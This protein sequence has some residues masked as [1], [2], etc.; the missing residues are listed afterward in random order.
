MKYSTLLKIAIALQLLTAI[1]HALSFLSDPVGTNDQEKMLIELMKTYQM[2]LG[3]G[4]HR[5]MTEVVNA[6]SACF[7]LLYLFGALI[8]WHLLRQQVSANVMKGVLG[9]N[10][11]IFG[12][13][14]ALMV[15][16]T[17]LPPIIMTGLTFVAL[18][19]AWKSVR[20]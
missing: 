20:Q 13:T 17:F 15:V 9:I 5:T 16:L 4:Y 18:F 19:A 8:N 6:L 12:F 3:A 1:A 14:F 2:D 10:L 7:S 11:A